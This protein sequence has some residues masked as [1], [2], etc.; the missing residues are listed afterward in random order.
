MRL[1]LI[2]NSAYSENKVVPAREAFQDS[3]ALLESRL[4]KED[5]NFHIVTLEAT[6]ELPE[7]LDQVLESHAGDLQE[8]LIH[9]SGY[10][11]ANSDRG[12]ALLL[13]G[14]RPRAFPVSRLRAS[15]APATRH[16]LVLMDVV[17]VADDGAKPDAVAKSL[18]VALNATTP[19]IAALS[20]VA[21]PEEFDPWLRGSL[22]LTDL[23]RLSLEHQG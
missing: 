5:T 3:G 1:A 7:Q 14:T 12:L 9:F 6:R 10:L 2:I 19:H 4:G 11:A 16:A 15:L 23:W 20:S 17:V 8:V 21:L 18:G 22:R 13:D